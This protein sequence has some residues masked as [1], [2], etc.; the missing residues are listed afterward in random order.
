MKV[1]EAPVLIVP[2]FNLSACGPELAKVS[3]AMAAGA[4]DDDD[5]DDD[6][7]ELCEIDTSMFVRVESGRCPAGAASIAVVVTEVQSTM[8][9]S[10]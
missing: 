3:A 10:Q 9:L 8:E 7:R 5:G 6:A 4:Q 1:K 2:A